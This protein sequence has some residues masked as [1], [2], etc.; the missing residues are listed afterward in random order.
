MRETVAK[1]KKAG[2]E[3]KKADRQRETAEE[4]EEGLSF[5][6][7]SRIKAQSRVSGP[8][9]YVARMTT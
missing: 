5:L 2:R 9:L 3:K 1:A 4:E 7:C 8:H 6:Y